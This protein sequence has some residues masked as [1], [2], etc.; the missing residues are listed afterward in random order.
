MDFIVQLPRTQTGF[1]AILVVVDRLTKMTHFCPTTTT[2][3]AEGTAKLFRDYVWKL[4]GVPDTLLTDRGSVFTSKFTKE[5]Y[6]LIGSEQRLTT[7]FHPQT[8]GQTERV[9]HVLEDML[10][11]YT[12][13]NQDDWDQFLSTAEFAVNNS[14]H[15]SIGTTPFRMWCGRD[16]RIPLRIVPKDYTSHQSKTPKAAEFADRMQHGLVEAKKKLEAA[17]QRQ[18][19]YY[20]SHHRQ[21]TFNVGDRVLLS[22]KNLHLKGI[23]C[24]KLAPKWVG[25]FTVI[26]QINPVAYKL[27]IPPCMRVHNVFH[28]SIL[29]MYHDDGRVQPPQP[30]E[31]EGEDGEFFSI[32][33]ILDHRVRRGRHT[34]REYLIRWQGYDNAHD[35]WEPES[36]ITHHD[37]GAL[38]KA[39]WDY[40]GLEMP[41]DLRL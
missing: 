7:A 9:N 1:D 13:A 38:I 37:N 20:D 11:H 5:L 35:S 41:P 3:T 29:R 21:V 30:F 19:R 14:H 18:K 10:R 16:P 8:D 15:E 33:R 4:H 26:K 27:E 12:D 23:K 25:P 2:V 34:P 32:E 24:R 39:Y 36:E 6:Q 17:Q 40:L 31:L 28:V 22:T